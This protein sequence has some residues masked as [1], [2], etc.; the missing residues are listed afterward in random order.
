MSTV[1][2]GVFVGVLL[3]SVASIASAKCDPANNPD[4]ATS[5]ANARAA[6]DAACDCSTATNHGAYVSCA[7]AAINSTLDGSDAQHSRSCRG[8]TKKC[9]AHSTCG[10]TDFVSC[11]KQS[12]KGTIKASIKSD[13]THCMAPNGGAACSN[14]VGVHPSVCDACADTNPPLCA[15]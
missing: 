13:S 5:I 10:K 12:A 6:A 3:L 8:T 2:R 9:Y 1:T 7:A 14:P 11:C 4:D 15:P